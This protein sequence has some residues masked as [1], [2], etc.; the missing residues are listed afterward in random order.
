MLSSIISK[1]RDIKTKFKQRIEHLDGFHFR[2]LNDEK[3]DVATICTVIFENKE[4]ADKVCKSLDTDTVNHSGWH[5][6]ANMEHMM[7]YFKE[8]GRPVQKGSFPKT[9]DILSR[10]VNVSVGVVDAGLG[11]GWG[12]NI[13]SDDKEIEQK[14]EEFI[15]A[16]KI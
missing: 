15:K 7:N 2:Q 1:L 8:I 13:H 4:K 10:S 12:M 6:Y 9:D 14:A 3:G 16:C 5:V 11:A